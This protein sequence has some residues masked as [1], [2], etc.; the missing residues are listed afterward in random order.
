VSGE[1]VQIQ[2]GQC[3]NQIGEKF[4]ETIT[5]E[6][7]LDQNGKYTGKNDVE[8]ERINVYFEEKNGGMNIQRSLWEI[9][10]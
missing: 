8:L 1:I 3:G 9:S 7:G 4:W 5:S 2:V 6:H 10:K